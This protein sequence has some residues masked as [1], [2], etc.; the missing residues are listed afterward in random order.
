[1]A[2]V[3]SLELRHERVRRNHWVFFC[4]RGQCCANVL[5]EAEPPQQRRQQGNAELLQRLR[6]RKVRQS[7]S[8]RMRDASSVPCAHPGSQPQRR[9]ENHGKKPMVSSL[10][11]ICH[12]RRGNM[13]LTLFAC[14]CA[15]PF[16]ETMAPRRTQAHVHI[17]PTVL[18]VVGHYGITKRAQPIQRNTSHTRLCSA[19]SAA[20]MT[21]WKST[22][23]CLPHDGCC[24]QVSAVTWLLLRP[25]STR[26]T[27]RLVVRLC[28]P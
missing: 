23:T 27:L 20:R 9:G 1:M 19:T 2:P 16:F 14:A 4:L 10:A 26:A 7:R 3:Q 22:A 21:A 6:N 18:C 5:A 24:R 25:C 13:T 8:V 28:L 12:P 15:D 17:T 11:L